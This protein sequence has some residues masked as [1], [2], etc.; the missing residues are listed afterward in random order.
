V[1]VTAKGMIYKLAPSF[2]NVTV[3][4]QLISDTGPSALPGLATDQAETLR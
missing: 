4:V 2:K 1:D 3:P